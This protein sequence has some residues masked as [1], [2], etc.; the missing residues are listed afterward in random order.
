MMWWFIK[1]G[2]NSDLF[3]LELYIINIFSIKHVQITR[4]SSLDM[5]SKFLWR[6]NIV[7]YFKLTVILFEL[8]VLSTWTTENQFKK[9]AHYFIVFY[10]KM[11]FVW[12]TEQE[13]KVWERFMV[14]KIAGSVIDIT[15]RANQHI[16]FVPPIPL[17]GARSS[18]PFL[19]VAL[20]APIH[21]H[22]QFLVDFDVSK[23]RCALHTPQPKYIL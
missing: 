13:R 17:P 19:Q 18:A 5:T 7:F 16:T 22:I 8:C 4:V 10:S 15:G 11:Q 20:S 1:H 2:V 14:Q 6:Q 12:Q 3:C 23:L 21:L 9:Q